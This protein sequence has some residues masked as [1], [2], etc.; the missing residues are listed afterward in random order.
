MHTGLAVSGPSRHHRGI[1]AACLFA[2]LLATLLGCGTQAPNVA[3]PGQ[4][5]HVEVA[6]VKAVRPSARDLVIAAYEGY[7]RATNEALASRDAARA[8]AIIAGFVPAHAA[9]ALVRGFRAIWRRDE[10]GYGSPV[11]HITS[12]TVT[13]LGRAAVHDCL[14]LSRTGF[15]NQQTGQVVGG[16]G[17]SHDLLITTLAL[18]HGRW[19]VTGAIPV[20]QTCRY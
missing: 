2:G 6:R 7:W 12:V 15:A 18:E 5:G 8:R 16:P 13:R 20:G 10:I 1:P 3:L 4:P 9:P 19:L 11:F 17:S 14:D